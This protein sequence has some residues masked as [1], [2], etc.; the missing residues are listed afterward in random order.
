MKMWKRCL[1]LTGF[2]AV[3]AGLA[4]SCKES[5]APMAPIGSSEQRTLG[6]TAANGD[7][8]TIVAVKFYDANGNGEKDAGELFIA[9]WPMYV[10]GVFIGNS[11]ATASVD[12]GL[13][14]VCEAEPPSGWKNT[15]DKC[16]E[17]EVAECGD[18]DGKTGPG[19]P[20][21]HGCMDTDCDGFDDSNPH[22]PCVD[23]AHCPDDPGC[24]PDPALELCCIN[25]KCVSVELGQCGHQGGTVVASCDD[26]GTPPPTHEL[27]CTDD[28]C[29]E[30]EIGQ[31]THGTVVASCNDCGTPDHELCCINDVCTEVEI[32]QC[33]H[34][35]GVL[36]T[37][38]DECGTPDHELC[39][40]N[41]VCTEVEVGQCGHQG[42]VL[43]T[44]CDEC[45][46]TEE[47]TP[48]TVWFGNLCVKG[49][50]GK[51]PGFWHNNNGQ[52]VMDAADV[53]ALAA[54]CLRNADGSDF[55]PTTK[56]QVG[57]WINGQNATNMAAKLSSFV[58]AMTL[59]IR[60]GYVNA[61]ALVYTGNGV[62][63]IGDVLN[64]GA[65]A[66]CADGYTPSGDEPNRTNQAQIKTILDDAC[67]NKNFVSTEPCDT[68]VFPLK[69]PIAGRE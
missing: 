3:I 58:A 44:S 39:C 1:V 35:G 4:L 2:L 40:I 30:V 7:G 9:G 13:H 12:P 59:N 66:I 23:C 28:V 67:N 26:C 22:T 61:G 49:G 62:D 17:I 32:G 54:L 56:A 43:V 47:C 45:G 55:N 6:S 33:G 50:G 24:N 42:G 51:T 46:T 60:H 31:C 41:E 38:C 21:N 14:T 29:T 64:A 69:A 63:E 53:T 8:P 10:D 52:A 19:V 37:S 68:P 25:D 57:A 5:T 48:D 16:Q 20:R 65:A 15:T 36:V 27:C 34:Q 11:P 18:H